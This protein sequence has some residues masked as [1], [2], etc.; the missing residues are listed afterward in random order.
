[1]EGNEREEAERSLKRHVGFS[2]TRAGMTSSQIYRVDFLLEADI[3]TQVAHHGDCIGADSDF[4]QLARLHGLEII[5]HPPL[6]EKL[7]AFCDFDE[8]REPKPYLDRDH[9]IVDE[10]DW[11]IFTPGT[12]TEILRSGTWATVRYAK[13]RAKDGFI[14]WSDGNFITLEEWESVF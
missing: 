3:I 14:I 12:L 7:R 2:G 8:C 9:D 13:K 10:S 6:V 4:H 1:M 11:L 5:G